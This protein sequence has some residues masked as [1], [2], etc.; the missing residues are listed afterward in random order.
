MNIKDVT[1]T[2]HKSAEENLSLMQQAL[3]EAETPNDR[4]IINQMY[5][6]YVKTLPHHA[7]LVK[8]E[9]DLQNRAEQDD[10]EKTIQFAIVE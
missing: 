10:G 7:R 2:F 4:T 9:Q 6:H 3:K 5:N 8:A 1:F